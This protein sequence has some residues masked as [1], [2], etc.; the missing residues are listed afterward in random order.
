[1]KI[2]KSYVWASL[3]SEVPLRTATAPDIRCPRDI[4]I[5]LVIPVTLRSSKRSSSF[6][7]EEDH[8]EFVPVHIAALTAAAYLFSKRASSLL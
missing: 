4:V 7:S 3:T 6:L 5:D 1:M 8:G 2:H